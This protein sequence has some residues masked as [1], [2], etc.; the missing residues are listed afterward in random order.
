V[1]AFAQSFPDDNLE[2]GCR[3]SIFDPAPAKNERAKQ[4]TPPNKTR[5]R[6]TLPVV[7]A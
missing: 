4:K 7:I 1:P 3:Q 2:Q 6:G 5:G